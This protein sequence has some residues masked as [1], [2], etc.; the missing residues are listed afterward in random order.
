MIPFAASL[1]Q[2]GFD[3]A[4]AALTSGRRFG[5]GYARA[6]LGY[7]FDDRVVACSGAAAI[8]AAAEALSTGGDHAA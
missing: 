1:V 4:T 8:A 7:S 5:N 6:V 3:Q 2:S